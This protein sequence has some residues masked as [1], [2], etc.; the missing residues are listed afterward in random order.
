M[1]LDSEELII[2]LFKQRRIKK[3][4]F[5]GQMQIPIKVQLKS[6]SCIPPFYSR[7]NILS[8]KHL[9]DSHRNGK[10]QLIRIT[11]SFKKLNII[12]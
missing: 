7:F 2:E 6:S 10:I 5:L 11:V 1:S 4:K 9:S 12:K 8:L 3:D